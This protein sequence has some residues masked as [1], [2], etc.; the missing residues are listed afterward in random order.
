MALWNRVALL[1]TESQR[2][3]LQ[4]ETLVLLVKALATEARNQVVLDAAEELLNTMQDEPV[5]SADPE[6]GTAQS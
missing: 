6:A 1:Q 4:V 3:R 5:P 2:R